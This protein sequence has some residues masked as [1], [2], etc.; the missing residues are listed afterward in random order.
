M[1]V[2][3]LIDTLESGGAERVAVN[4]ANALSNEIETSFLC[5]TRKEGLLKEDICIKV[6]YLFLN[7]TKTIDVK[8]IKRLYTFVRKHKIDVI[9]AHSSSFFLATI[10]K[11]LNQKL[12]IVWHDHYGNTEF[13]Q[14][15]KYGVLRF[16]SKYFVH[17][18]SV[19]KVLEVWAKQNL[20]TKSISYLPNFATINTIKAVTILKGTPNKRIVCLANFRS[21]KDHITL[22][23]AFKEVIKLH[24]GWSL[25]CVGKNFNDDY[26]QFVENKIKE[27]DITSS[28]F[29]YDSKPDVFNILS[30]CNI[31]VLSS[32]SEGLPLALLEYGLSNLAVIATNVGECKT[33]I[34]NNYN[35]LLVDASAVK[36][37]SKAISSYIEQ[38]ELRN[39]HASRYKKHIQNNYSEKSQLHNILKVYKTYISL[40]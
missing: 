23:R 28:V 17:I 18:F 40:N 24:P 32:K 33:V 26:Y 3:Q 6:Q 29:L 21:Q 14:D 30:Q 12:L 5:A 20:K 31:G 7:K 19:N 34:T 8:A 27:L 25:H 16:C 36:D 37:L 4:L 22:L 2:L 35:G 39:M 15:R 38:K 1:R 9:H 13:L 10:V 11:L